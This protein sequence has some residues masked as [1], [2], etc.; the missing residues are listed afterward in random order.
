MDE[1]GVATRVFPTGGVLPAHAHRAGERAVGHAHRT[2]ILH[3]RPRLF[4]VDELIRRSL[5]FGE[6][7]DDAALVAIPEGAVYV[8]PAEVPHFLWAKDGAVLYQE[9]GLAPTATVPVSP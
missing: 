2:E 6:A 3:V 8:A 9:N 5:G 4:D 7:A 1:A